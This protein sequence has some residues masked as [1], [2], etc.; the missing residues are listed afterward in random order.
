MV[1]MEQSATSWLLW[2]ESRVHGRAC[3]FLALCGLQAPIACRQV[4]NLPALQI[5]SVAPGTAYTNRDTPVTIVGSNFFAL[6]RGA[7]DKAGRADTGFTVHLGPHALAEVSYG[8]PHTLH[9]EVL[10]GLPAGDYDLWVTSPAGLRARWSESFLIVEPN[11]GGTSGNTAP[12]AD[13]TISAYAAGPGQDLIFD[14]SPTWDREDPPSSL[15]FFWDFDGDGNRDLAGELVT[16]SFLSTGRHDVTLWA[17]DPGGLSGSKRGFV[18]VDN[19]TDIIWVANESELAAALITPGPK[20]IALQPGATIHLSAP[21]EEDAD[22]TIVVGHPDAVIDG[23]GTSADVDC[24]RLDGDRNQILYLHVRNCSDDGIMV[25]GDFNTIAACTAEGVFDDGFQVHGTSNV[26]GPGNLAYGSGRAGFKVRGVDALVF[27]NVARF[28]GGVGVH[29]PTSSRPVA[30]PIIALNYLFANDDGG[31][32]VS[33]ASGSTDPTDA[34]I[35]NNTIAQ[36]AGPGIELELLGNSSHEVKNNLL[37]A[38]DEGVSVEGGDVYLDYNAYFGNQVADCSGCS[39]GL[40]AF[41]DDPLYVDEPAGDLRL[42]PG[43]PYID[44]GLDRGFDLN[45]PTSSGLFFGTAP[46]IGAYQLPQS[47]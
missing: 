33:G 37:T 41:F 12:I 42:R 4:G 36:S 15:S 34:S 45:G 1:S 27:G 28:N 22:D 31:V 10:A 7:P 44:A 11:T 23:S 14:A 20:V 47:P 21:M 18:V 9:A 43:S 38:N 24:L 19:P 29:A 17:V 30:A 2:P 25:S 35:W 39:V 40:N 6:V 3:L 13:F 26:L 5:D 8:D 46:D 16:H 32:R